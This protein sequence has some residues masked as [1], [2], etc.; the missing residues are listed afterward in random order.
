M[1]DAVCSNTEELHTNIWAAGA[2][3]SS[4]E[5]TNSE[6]FQFENRGWI[7]P[8]PL[9]NEQGVRRITIMGKEAN[10]KFAL[11]P[12]M[13]CERPWFKSM[14]A[15]V[16][17]F[18]DIANHPAIVNRIKAVLGP[19]L[20]VWGLCITIR[21]PG[22]VHRWHV[23]V[24]H[25]R[26]P[27]VTV[28]LGLKGT[29]QKSTLKMISESHKINAMPQELK[30]KSDAA[31]V[32]KAQEFQPSSQLVAVNLNE[33]EFFIFD[34]LLWHGSHNTDKQ[35]RMAMVIH[36]SRPNVRVQIPLNWDEPIV[37]SSTSPP[38]VLVSGEDHYGVN[39]LVSSAQGAL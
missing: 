14:H 3:E 12:Q 30:I 37:W 36:Y 8:Y 15:Y 32:E 13:S 29:S 22:Q 28:F 35:S 34:G 1:S 38:C 18:F 9:L 27:G 25:R 20:I 10:N 11:G 7:G 5:V 24:E 21:R 4:A 23:D 19:D 16:P 39:K 17:E 26:W 33:G 31:A 6:L 2:L